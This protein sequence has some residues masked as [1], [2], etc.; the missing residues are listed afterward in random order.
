MREYFMRWLISIPL[1][2][3]L[4]GCA[5][6][7]Y[8]WHSTRGHLTLMNQ[9]VDIEDMLAGDEIDAELRQRLQWLQEIRR[10]SI[11]RLDL[12]DNGSYD[13]YVQLVRP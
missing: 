4:C 1:L 3:L 9:R 7:G 11:E 5:D 2:L 8:Y 10:F 6:L 13:S 12:P